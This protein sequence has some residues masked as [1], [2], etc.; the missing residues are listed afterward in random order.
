MT[1]WAPE[2]T[3]TRST[4][5]PAERVDDHADLEVAEGGDPDLGGE[6]T[7]LRQAE[8]ILVIVNA[9]EVEPART[10]PRLGGGL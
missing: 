7:A 1:T 4:L 10:V 8:M 2:E 3:G 5:T 6:W 9:A